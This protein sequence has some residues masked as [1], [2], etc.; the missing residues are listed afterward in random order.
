MF[1]SDYKSH[2]TVKV[3]FGIMPGIGFNFISSAYVGSISDPE[4][5]IKSG[6]LNEAL[7]EKGDA[8]MADRGFTVQDLFEP[9]GVN[10]ILPAFLCGREQ[11]TEEETFSVSKLLLKEF[12]LN[13]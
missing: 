12:M 13:G 7:W 1:Y 10:D 3:L 2:E 4:I 6:I 11:L 9:R 8:I 5:T